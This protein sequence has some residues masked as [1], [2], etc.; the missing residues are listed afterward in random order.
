MLNMHT[1][2]RL[3]EIAWAAGLFEGEGC[4]THAQRGKYFSLQ[5]ELGMTDEDSVREFHRI[6]KVGNI[7]FHPRNRPTKDGGK[8]KDV[9][10]WKVASFEGVQYVAALFWNYLGTRRKAK[11]KEILTAYMSNT[12]IRRFT[13]ASPEEVDNVRVLL[14]QGLG[15]RTIA[16][17]VG[18]SYGFVNHIK[19][20][21]THGEA[22]HGN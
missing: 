2:S 7:T 17:L 4:F 9:W 12:N 8:E 18:R 21:R 10:A 6:V 11:I 3:E 15:K 13:L 20:G 14:A 16:R 22:A 19:L 5:C 1:K